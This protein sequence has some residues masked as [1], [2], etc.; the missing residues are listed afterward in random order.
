MSKLRILHTADWHLDASNIEYAAPAIEQAIRNAP[1]YDLF[2]FAGDIA[3]HRGN[4][5]PDIAWHARR[6]LTLGCDRARYGGIMVAGNHD[7]SFR[8]GVKGMAAGIMGG[9][10]PNK[11]DGANLQVVETPRLVAVT[12]NANRMLAHFACFPTPTKYE[13][14]RLRESGRDE[15]DLSI[16][17]GQAIQG[18]RYSV[19]DDGAPLFAIYHGGI[20]GARMGNEMVMRAGVD[21]NVSA[22]AFIGYRAVFAGHIHDPQSIEYDSGRCSLFYPG[23]P[24]PLT[25]N[26]KAL[27]PRMLHH[28]I[29]EDDTCQSVDV[30]V[31]VLSQM[32]DLRIEYDESGPSIESVVREAL[33]R[34]DRNSGDR[35][36]VTVV[37]PRRQLACISRAFQTELIDLAG[38]KSI[39][40]VMEPTDLD[41]ITT[42]DMSDA[43]AMEDMF[44]AWASRNANA[45]GAIVEI[46]LDHV[47]AI[48]GDVLDKHLDAHYECRPVSIEATNWCQYDSM[49]LDF[50]AMGNV[51]AVE[52]HNFAGKSNIARLFMFSRYKRQAS[53]DRISDLVRKGCESMSVVEVFESSGVRYSIK[54]T[55]KL[56]AN[57]GARAD[58]FLSRWDGSGWEVMNEGTAGETQAVIDALVGPYELFMATTYAGQNDVDG[59]VDLTP[60]ELKDTMMTVL[61][62]DFESRRIA[63]AARLDAVAKSIADIHDELERAESLVAREADLSASL[64]VKR[65][66]TA[67]AALAFASSEEPDGLRGVVDSLIREEAAAVAAIADADRAEERLRAAKDLAEG[68]REQKQSCDEAAIELMRDG[69]DG[70]PT[71]EDLDR[72]RASVMDCTERHAESRTKYEDAHNSHIRLVEAQRIAVLDADRAKSKAQRAYE[73]ANRKVNDATG[74]AALIDNVPCQGE[75]LDNAYDDP[76][77]CSECVLLKEAVAAQKSRPQLMIESVEREADLESAADLLDYLT[78]THEKAASATWR[79]VADAKA[80]LDAVERELN[81]QRVTQAG[82]Q[83][84]FQRA[85]KRREHKADLEHRVSMRDLALKS[86]AE[87]ESRVLVEAMALDAVMQQ[88]RRISDIRRTRDEAAAMLAVSIR[89]RETLLASKARARE[90]ELLVEGALNECRAALASCADRRAEQEM[91]RLEAQALALV[92]Q[93]MHRDGIPFMMLAQYAIPMMQVTMNEYLQNTDVRVSVESTAELVSGKQRSEVAVT[94]TDHRGRHP[95]SAASGYQRTVIGMAMRNALADLHAAATGSRIWLSIQ[96]EGFGTMDEGNLDRAKDT[97]RLIAQKRGWFMFI[98]HVP[99]MNDTADTVIVVSDAGTHSTIAV[100]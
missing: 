57:G 61:Q 17:M 43:F 75:V 62:R 88:V 13:A 20:G 48:E 74:R 10:D 87:A 77:D 32:R 44:R 28:T 95:L 81:D 45:S 22:S 99:G 51:I 98:S 69:T 27:I 52:G 59:L 85:V 93:A 56:T 80:W 73:D 82:I 92:V 63:A 42:V 3:V 34:L 5:H 65:A 76:V 9:V 58:V 37:G 97:L 91:L 2:I 26:D 72:A 47:A 100:R 96:D 70:A 30:P 54:R 67:D 79:T 38:V 7:L 24:V 41:A 49:R 8:S 12:N 39:K 53:G 55:V 11:S 15:P 40:F 83:E 50:N 94:F 18:M 1:E 23:A 60:S 86:L 78:K 90:D 6:L 36:R 46:A 84:Q 16:L 35:V 33:I 21:I 14:E 31:L 64:E 29:G 19:P 66:A 4:I 71:E 68:W 89:R 25:W